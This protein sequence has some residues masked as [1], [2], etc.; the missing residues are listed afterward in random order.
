[1]ALAAL[2]CAALLPAGW[3]VAAD[4]VRLKNGNVIAGTVISQNDRQVVIEIPGTGALTVDRAEV[5]AITLSAAAPEAAPE[6]APEVASPPTDAAQPALSPAAQV[7]QHL[8]KALEAIA[9]RNYGEA[10]DYARKAVAADPKNPMGHSG[11]GNIYAALHEYDKAIAALETALRLN[12]DDAGALFGLGACYMDL[13]QHE[14]AIPYLERVVKLQ[15]GEVKL[16][17]ALAVAY[18]RRG[19]IAGR[20][21]GQQAKAKTSLEAAVALFRKTGN[22]A[23]VAE[24]T[25]LLKQIP[26]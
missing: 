16:T 26:Q 18:V 7:E 15:P 14:K 23:R 24:L 21:G 3:P 8:R 9:Q 11:L 10:L 6:P 5:T 22:A 12:P 13:Q 1:M 20:Q 17:E 2:A 19:I 25:E 4:E